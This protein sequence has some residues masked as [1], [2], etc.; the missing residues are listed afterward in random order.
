MSSNRPTERKLREIFHGRLNLEQQK[1]R[2]K[3]LLKALKANS[4]E[5]LQRL[6][7]VHS[8]SGYSKDYQLADA[9]LVLA[10]ENGFASWPKMKAHCEQ[11]A[12][13]KRRID[14]GEPDRLDTP[15]TTHIRCGSDIRHTLKIA[16]FSGGF[17]EFADPYCQGPVPHL[18]DDA[19][20]ATRAKFIAEAYGMDQRE[21]LARLGKE[22]AALTMLDS[23]AEPILWFEHD[24]YDQLILA[25]VLY[26]L[27]NMACRN[28]AQIICVD[29]VPG[30][31]DFT[32]LGQ[33]S[34]EALQWLWRHRRES[35]SDA[36]LA[37]GQ[38]VWE[39][40]TNP[41]PTTL[42]ELARNGT[43]AIPC[44]ANALHRHLQELPST[45][46][47]LGLTQQ[48]TLTI[49]AEHDALTAGEVFRILCLE[50]EPLPYLGDTMFWHELIDLGRSVTP[51]FDI[52][53]D[54]V[55]SP[56]PKRRLSITDTGRQLLEGSLDFLS[57]Y[58]GERWIGGVRVAGDAP[59]PRWDTNN[60]SIT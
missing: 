45:F 23:Y 50:R 35:V 59:C 40:L 14:A 22:Y 52:A 34:P 27:P 20:I 9:Q 4:P 57:L 48:L 37:L 31:N 54:G 56:W 25:R 30:V 58:Q 26:T 43:P 47:G 13:A 10:R 12:A 36:H 53:Q 24:T 17:L 49:I 1:K 11:L 16:G 15:Q 55:P 41:D 19:F 32:G 18:S 46:N 60:R 42:F 8:E 5:A 38:Q 2:A 29:S 3:T 33:L 7:D 21:T 51:L 44:M 6:R 39:T 28:N